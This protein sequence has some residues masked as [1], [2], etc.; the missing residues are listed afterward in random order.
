MQSPL[1][2]H[3]ASKMIQNFLFIDLFILPKYIWF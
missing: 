2:L 3:A 1:F